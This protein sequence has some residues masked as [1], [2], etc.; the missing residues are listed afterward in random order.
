MSGAAGVTFLFTERRNRV[1]QDWIER[2]GP[3]AVFA[4]LLVEGEVALLLA[5][6]AVQHGYLELLPTLLLGTAGGTC[7]DSVYYWL[8][9][10]FGARV[11]RSRPALR[12]LRAR[13]ILLL[14]RYGHI[15]AFFTRFAFGM[16][17]ALP[18]AMGAA[19]MHPRVFHLYNALGSLA[20]AVVYL[21][22]GYG[23][24]RAVHRM[25]QRSNIS[26]EHVMVAVILL[27]ILIWC[28]REWRLYHAPVVPVERDRPPPPS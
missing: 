16:R 22:L 15:M 25:I 5:G 23:L 8:G 18:A 17:I 2:F 19:R 9:R 24:G 20:F 26:E 28:V 14:R 27:G 12:P 3:W 11:L 6:V 13:A 7:S 10:R 21:S 4:G 1:W